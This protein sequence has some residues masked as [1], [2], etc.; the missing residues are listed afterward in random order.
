MMHKG[1]FH[2]VINT[3]LLSGACSLMA[4]PAIAQQTPPDNT[5]V[6]QADRAKG[7]VTADK[8]K[9]NA[10]DRDLAKRIRQSVVADKSLSTYAHNVKIVA[11]GGQVTIKGPVRSEAEKT[12]IETKATEIAG[13][14]KVSNEITIAPAAAPK[15]PKS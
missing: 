7:A 14:G 12:A 13:P 5:K 10:T 15:T 6:N 8:Q 11:Q 4:L 2:R 9:E 1:R 3:L